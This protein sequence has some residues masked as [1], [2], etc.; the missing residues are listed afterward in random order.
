MMNKS[1]SHKTPPGADGD[2]SARAKLDR[3]VQL[4]IGEGLR[5]MY[6]DIVKQGVPD[7]FSDL[8]KKLDQPGGDKQDTPQK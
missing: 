2:K 5:A 7:R 3:D 8:L 6:A 4:R 1:N